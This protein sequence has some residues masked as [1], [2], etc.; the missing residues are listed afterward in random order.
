MESVVAT[1][2]ER[3][4]S[5]SNAA[6]MKDNGLPAWYAVHVRS[7]HEFVAYH[8]LLRRGIEAFLPSVTKVSQWSDR[9]KRIEQPLF[10][11][12]LFVQLPLFAGRFGTVLQTRGVVAFISLGGNMPAAVSAEEIEALKLMVRSGK[13]LDLYPGMK[14]GTRVRI[15]SGP[16]KTAIGVVTAREREYTFHVNVELL[17]RSVAVAVCAEDIEAV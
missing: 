8:E 10:Q 2:E 14:T 1:G 4:S 7:R 3:S 17:G 16:L 12:Y 9:K 15:K 5:C 6:V 11:G 13:D